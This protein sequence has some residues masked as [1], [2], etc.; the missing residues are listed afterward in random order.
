MGGDDGSGI[1]VIGS[2]SDVE[3]RGNTGI[4]ANADYGGSYAGDPNSGID[5]T[6]DYH[7][8]YGDGRRFPR[9]L[10]LAGHRRGQTWIRAGVVRDRHRRIGVPFKRDDADRFGDKSD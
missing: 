10:D 9:C 8:Y 6:F 7:L 4:R 1:R 3:L 2:G 5:N